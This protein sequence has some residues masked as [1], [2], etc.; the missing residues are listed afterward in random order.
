ML[1]QCRN[2]LLLVLPPYCQAGLRYDD[3]VIDVVQPNLCDCYDC[4][5]RLVLH[6]APEGLIES[7]FIAVKQV[8]V[9]AAL[10]GVPAGPY[11]HI[12]RL[13]GHI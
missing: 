5:W 8:V 10:P 11:R 4:A 3:V 9:R 7:S 2:L 6:H 12:A 13:K 1:F